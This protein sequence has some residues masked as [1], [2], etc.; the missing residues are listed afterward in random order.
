MVNNSNV[1]VF[2]S[3]LGQLKTYHDSFDSM[4]QLWALH[5]IFFYDMLSR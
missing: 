1:S 5:A 4:P 2:A 3:I